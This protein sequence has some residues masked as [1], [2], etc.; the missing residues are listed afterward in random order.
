MLVFMWSL[1]K[2]GGLGWAIAVLYVVCCV[3]R[4]ARFNV[5][6]SN[7]DIPAWAGRQKVWDTLFKAVKFGVFQVPFEIARVTPGTREA[8]TITACCLRP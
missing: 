2:A 6:S 4:L 8:R 3:L 1:E 5:A 7:P